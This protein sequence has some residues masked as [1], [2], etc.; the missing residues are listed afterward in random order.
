ML[1]QDGKVTR[2]CVTCG[3]RQILGAA[4]GK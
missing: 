4:G 2:T 1:H 3:R